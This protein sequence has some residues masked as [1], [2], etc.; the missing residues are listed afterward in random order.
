M[1]FWVTNQYKSKA[2]RWNLYKLGSTLPQAVARRVRDS[3]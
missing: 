3:D 1:V 2:E